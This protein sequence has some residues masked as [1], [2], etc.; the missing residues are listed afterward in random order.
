MF[1]KA[2]QHCGGFTRPVVIS[3]LRNDGELSS[4]IGTFIH[5]NADGWILTA[6]HIVQEQ[7]RY[8]KQQ[9][10][11]R[12]SD[13]RIAA[14]ESSPKNAKEKKRL[15]E[16]ERRN[17]SKLVRDFSFWWAS[18]A[19]RIAE[20]A[21]LETADI[22]L[23]RLAPFDPTSCTSYPTFKDPDT[24]LLVG[25]SVCR[26]GYPFS[27]LKP[28]YSAGN[29]LLPDEVFKMP[30]FPNEGIITRWVSNGT[31]GTHGYRVGF[32]ETSSAGLRGQSGGPIFDRHGTVWGIQSQTRHMP[33]GF[34]PPVP[35]GKPGQVEHQFM[36]VGW[37]THPATLVGLMRETNVKF[38]LSHY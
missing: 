3:T 9:Q 30:R 8:A 28:S 10:E 29:F 36:N 2:Y 15:V 13:A 32:L 7:A 12:E 6:A 26:L 23:C 33:L 27:Q 31:H 11:V 16:A 38:E 1:A 25:T 5:V 20:A 19:A 34:S 21:I 24:N 22:A 14:V 18:D 17:T 37:G 4:A 35:G